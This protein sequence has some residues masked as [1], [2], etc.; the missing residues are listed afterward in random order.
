MALRDLTRRNFLRAGTATALAAGGTLLW[1]HESLPAAPHSA[2]DG[3][4]DASLD[5]YVT[6]YMRA[7]NAPG[8]TL[9]MTDSGK[10]QRVAGY[11]FA[12]VDRRIAVGPDHLFQIGSITKSFVA[13]VVLQLREEG[14]V[15]LQRPILEYLPGL[16]IAEG[17]GPITVHHL[18]THTS[19]LPDNQSVFQ[20]DPAARLVQGFKPGEHF[21]YCNA[22]FDILG[23][24]AS[25]LDARPWREC[26]RERIFAP[27]GMTETCGVITTAQRDRSAVGYEGFWDDQV[28]PRQ[29][30]LAPA[31][32]LVMDNTAG[33]IAST[34]GDMARYLRMLLR[35]GEA[36]DRRIVS[37]ESF[38]L[39]STAYIKAPEF[40]PTAS[41]GYGV[42]VDAVD[43]HKMLRHTGGMVA[44]ASS[45][46]VDLDG[47]VAAFAS[48][49]AMQGYRPIAVTEYAVR[50][51]RAARESKS[52]PVRPEITNPA[53]VENA[54][55]YAGKFTAPGGG[56]LEF[57]AQGN[58]LQVRHASGMIPL[59]RD[60][61]DSFISTKAGAFADYSF[62]FGRRQ[63]VAG[64]SGDGQSHED[65]AHAKPP[66]VEV[67]YGPDWHANQAYD[68]PREFAMPEGHD[69][70]VGN[71]RSEDAWGGSVRVYALK[72]KLKLSGISLERIGGNLF[73]AGEE[74]W[75]PDTVEFLH[76]F[77]GK[78]RIL[79]MLGTE[80]ARVDV[81]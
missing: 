10:T 79:R 20:N 34:P 74:A 43:G 50:L 36:P 16:P 57:V 23:L 71:Y 4:L 60:G 2:G 37:E 72:G 64:S 17:F 22:G 25:K 46:H 12:D 53:K 81:D 52:L 41:Y 5:A 67:S 13:L 18:L 29:G 27:L 7:M 44:F 30:R 75:V 47:G 19:G 24:L 78:A 31:P 56:S 49:N 15:D 55:D 62:E 3:P 45:M 26:V 38:G 32:N 69:S 21:H 42:A 54:A 80:F 48:I 33:C 68:G 77:E 11:G 70:L 51:M 66:V 1:S 35:R 6:D 73:R 28:Y 76:I 9:G 63:P 8:L 39:F 65:A 14:K 40:S 59:Q 61:E 58:E